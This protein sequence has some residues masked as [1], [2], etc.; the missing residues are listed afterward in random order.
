[1]SKFQVKTVDGEIV[2]TIAGGDI[3]LE[4]YQTIDNINIHSV[5]NVKFK[6]EGSNVTAIQPTQQIDYE[7]YKAKLIKTKQSEILAEIQKRYPPV[8]CINDME[9][10]NEIINTI[11]GQQTKLKDALDYYNNQKLEITKLAKLTVKQLQAKI[12]KSIT[13]TQ[14][15]GIK[16]L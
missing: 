12:D 11:N 8:T 9:Q 5:D 2:E 7:K 16:E 10:L 15:T 6:I 13:G 4:N 3:E 14:N 1:M